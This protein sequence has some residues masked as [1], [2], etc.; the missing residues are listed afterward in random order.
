LP[1]IIREEEAR[2]FFAEYIR[3]FSGKTRDILVRLY[4]S[5]PDNEDNRKWMSRA[6]SEF[7]LSEVP[8]ICLNVGKDILQVFKHLYPSVFI[9]DLLK[10]SI[11]LYQKLL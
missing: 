11:P 5:L 3:T 4:M 10:P 2:L 7:K 8:E 1:E 9:E 6:L